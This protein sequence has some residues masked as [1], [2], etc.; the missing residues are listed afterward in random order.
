MKRVCILFLAACSSSSASDAVDASSPSSF[1]RVTFGAL[2]S[3]FQ[4]YASWTNFYVGDVPDP[5][6]VDLSG[7]R[8]VYINAMPPRGATE[9]PVGTII[10]KVIRTGDTPDTWQMFGLV[11]RGG[12][13]DAQGAPGWEWFGLATNASNAVTIEWRGDGPP[14]DGGYGGITNL[15]CIYCHTQA[16]ANDYVQTPELQLADLQ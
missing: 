13:F 1:G 2:A 15:G 7:P 14:P 8:T 6:G 9:F 3:D 10:V 11:K 16:K 4:P 12:D 5:N